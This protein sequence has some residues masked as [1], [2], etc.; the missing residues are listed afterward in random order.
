[1]DSAAGYVGGVRQNNDSNRHGK[2]N[3]NKPRFVA[4][5]VGLVVILLGFAG[6]WMLYKS[7]TNSSIDS[8]KYQ[9]LFLTNGQ[10]YFGKLQILNSEYVKLTD[11]YYLQTTNTS[12]DKTSTL[13]NASGNSTGVQLIKLG[14]EIHGPSDEMVVNRDQVLFFENIKKDGQV[15]SSI[16]K[17]QESLKK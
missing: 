13:Q 7:S 10:V 11:I 14:S 16:V 8:N 9:A 17:Y 12:D 15:T 6:G 1:M 2:T 3:R 4:L 5:I